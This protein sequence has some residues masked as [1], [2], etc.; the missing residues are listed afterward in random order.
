MSAS[1]VD[2]K[3]Q[4]S[5]LQILASGTA[6]LIR[7]YG[8]RWLSVK[9]NPSNGRFDIKEAEIIVGSILEARLAGG[10]KYANMHPDKLMDVLTSLRTTV[11]DGNGFGTVHPLTRRTI[12]S[13]WKPRKKSSR[14]SSVAYHGKFL[15]HQKVSVSILRRYICGDILN[16]L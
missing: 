11:S 16:W 1:A 2:E 12:S 7:I 8:S 10:A 5:Y 13:L 4:W 15:V 3:F 6:I 14:V 9:I